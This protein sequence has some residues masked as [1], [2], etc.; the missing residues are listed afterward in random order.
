HFKS[1]GDSM[2]IET[3]MRALY[4]PSRMTVIGTATH[5]LVQNATSLCPTCA[6]PGFVVTD[7]RIGLP[8]SCCGAATNSVVS[9]LYQCKYCRFTCEDIYPH[10]KKSED[11]GFC[12]YCN[13]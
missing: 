9:H 10:Q 3:D 8:C 7:V 13:P 12:N 11:P 6:M 4:N 1:L 2:F 5:K